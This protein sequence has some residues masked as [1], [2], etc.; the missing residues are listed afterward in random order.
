MKLRWPIVPSIVLFVAAA[1]AGNTDYQ[2]PEEI[3]G[4][5]TVDVA[6][7][8]RLHQQGVVF[9]DVRSTRLHRRQH[10]P[11]AVHL[12]LNSRFTEAELAQT[13]AKDQP[14]V[15]YCSGATCTRSFRAVVRAVR[16]GYT[17]VKYFRGGVVDWRDA[18]L[19]LTKANR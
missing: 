4:A 12:D 13:V 16:W 6:E 18:G 5:E 11:G 10:I 17:Q 8:Q 19:A 1:G 15:V 14:F 3:A 9:V 2:S 7:A